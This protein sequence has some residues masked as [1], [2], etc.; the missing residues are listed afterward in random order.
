MWAVLIGSLACRLKADGVTAAAQHSLQSLPLTA[1]TAVRDCEALATAD[2]GSAGAYLRVP[3][4]SNKLDRHGLQRQL[5]T[6]LEFVSGHLTQ[7]HRVLLHCD[8]GIIKISIFTCWLETYWVVVVWDSLL[9]NQQF[10][11]CCHFM[12]GCTVVADADVHD[13]LWQ[14]S[15]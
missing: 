14:L 10:C 11:A 9:G 5:P 6:A 13:V 3:V 15:S 1:A 12:T 2:K 7:Q 8:A 4:A